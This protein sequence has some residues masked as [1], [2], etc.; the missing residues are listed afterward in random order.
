MQTILKL[1]G[2]EPVIRD[3]TGTRG[4]DG[5]FKRVVYLDY[6][7]GE[8]NGERYF[9]TVSVMHSSK[10]HMAVAN[11]LSGDPS[12]NFTSWPLDQTNVDQQPAP[13]YSAK[14]LKAYACEIADQVR[15]QLDSYPGPALIRHMVWPPKH[16]E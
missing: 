11:V 5:K 4:Y 10:R 16:A 12:G 13:R 6:P 15:A 14:A 8:H 2:V 1:A 9:L 7:L 3:E